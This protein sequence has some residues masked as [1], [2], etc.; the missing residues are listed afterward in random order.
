MF[1][2]HR[3]RIAD[4]IDNPGLVVPHPRGDELAVDERKRV[5]RVACS[6]SSDESAEQNLQDHSNQQPARQ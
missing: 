4:E 2:M 5:R 6:M 3:Q 1:E